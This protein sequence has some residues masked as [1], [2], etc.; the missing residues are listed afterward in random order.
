MYKLEKL[1]K[2]YPKE[3]E[4]VV[5]ILYA[6]IYPILPKYKRSPKIYFR[7]NALGQKFDNK[8]ATTNYID[9]II[10]INKFLNKSIIFECLGKYAKSCM[11]EFPPSVRNSK[12]EIYKISDDFYV[13]VNNGTPTKKSHIIKLCKSLNISLEII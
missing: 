6:D 9:F 7:F 10:L 11:S 3:L 1:K 13:S 8:K 5:D 4:E 12:S 2:D